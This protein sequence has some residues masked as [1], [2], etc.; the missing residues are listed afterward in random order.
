M[1]AFTDLSYNKIGDSAGDTTSLCFFVGH[2]FL[3]T[4]FNLNSVSRSMGDPFRLSEFKSSQRIFLLFQKFL[5]F[6]TC[7]HCTLYLACGNH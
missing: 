5:D 1:S 7:L 3:P 4:P 6:Q 2:F